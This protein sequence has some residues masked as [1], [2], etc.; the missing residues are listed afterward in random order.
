MAHVGTA[1]DLALSARIAAPETFAPYGRLLGPGDR[2]SLVGRTT[3]GSGGGVLLA[4]DRAEPGP[5]RIT[6]LQRYPEARRVLLPLGPG[7]LLLVVLPPGERP[8]GPPAAFVVPQGQGVLLKEGVWHAGP[9]PLEEMPVAE[10]LET[11]GP[12]DRMD[13]RT[14]RELVGAEG[15]RVLLPEE[16]GARPPGFDLTQ[17]NSVLLDATLHGRFRLGC[18][19]LRD[20]EVGESDAALQAEGERLAETLRS[21]YG[22]MGGLDDVPGIEA[23]RALFR[24]V[25]LDPQR[26]RPSSEALVAL[27]LEG[28]PLVRVNALVDTLHLCA[29]KTRVPYAAYDAQRLAEQVLVRAGAPGEAYPGLTRQRVSAE[30]RPVL[31]DREGPFGGPA[32]DALRTRVT[33]QTRRA[34]VVL[35]LAPALERAAVERLLG[36]AATEVIARCGGREAARLVVG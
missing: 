18:L 20:L 31:C 29:L 34:L 23:T 35:F 7:A 1:G 28:R 14:L 15:A 22:S 12:V 30:G 5:R 27:A 9:V 33:H 8:G 17:P 10:V 4:L 26:I 2:V 6:H 19:D 11:S 3:G 32:G 16:P 25:G 36:L 21:T 24:G 13:R